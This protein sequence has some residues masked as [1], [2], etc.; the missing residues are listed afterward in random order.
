[1]IRL[2][3]HLVDVEGQGC[4][5]VGVYNESGVSKQFFHQIQVNK[6][7]PVSRLRVLR[8]EGSGYCCPP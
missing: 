5:R 6:R 7:R 4:V 1:M 8:E 3:E 2:Q